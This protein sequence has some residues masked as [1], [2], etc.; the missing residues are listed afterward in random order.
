MTTDDEL[1]YTS[2]T[3]LARRVRDAR[4]RPSELLESVIERI[5]AA[6]PRAQRGRVHRLRRRAAAPPRRPSAAVLAGDR[7]RPAAR[8]ADADQGPVRL[9]A[10]LDLDVRRRAGARRSGDRRVLHVR[11][12]RRARRRDPRR[13]DQQ[14]R[15]GHPRHLRQPVVRPVAQPVRHSRRTP[16]AR[17]AAA[18][19]P[20]PTASCRSPR[21][22]TP[23]VRSASRRPGAGCTAS[24]PSWGRVPVALRPNVFAGT[25]PFVAEGPITRTVED[26]ALGDVGARRVRLARPVRAAPTRPTSWWRSTADLTGKR[27]AYSPDFGVYPVDPDVARTVA[28]AVQRVRGSR[29]DRRGGRHR[30]SPTITSS[31]PTCGVA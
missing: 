22:P 3:E 10:G 29:C 20:S 17:R 13:Q 16:A 21:A 8:R 7:A 1:A 24:K 19:L 28:A 25:S 31:T 15:D 14:P 12:A 4:S 23:A 9:Q 11:R 18:P 27:I 30:R 6:Q 5:E 2:A 26:A